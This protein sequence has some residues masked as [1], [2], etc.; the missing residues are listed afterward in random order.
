VLTTAGAVMPSTDPIYTL[1]KLSA[2][3]G[4]MGKLFIE[5]KNA[6][7]IEKLYQFKIASNM[8]VNELPLTFENPNRA[9]IQV[10]LGCFE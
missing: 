10:R 9:S 5:T 1:L 8:R 2:R 3:T 4:P 6:D 7:N